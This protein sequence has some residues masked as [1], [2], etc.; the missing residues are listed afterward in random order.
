[1][2]IRS[3]LLLEDLKGEWLTEMAEL[4]DAGC[5]AFGQ[6][7]MPLPNTRVLMQAMQYAS[8]FGFGVWLRPQDVNLA[9][10]GV[11]HDG[12][13]ATRLG[14]PA[15]SGLCGNACV[16]EY[17]F[18]GARNRR[19]GSLVPYFQRGRRCHDPCSPSGKACPL[20]AT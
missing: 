4:R 8:T 14:L 16:V 7:D 11:A 19:Q 6:S 10:G 2:S 9:D 5:I 15:D 12:E 1:M 13:V 3:G 17:Y 20:P 18:D